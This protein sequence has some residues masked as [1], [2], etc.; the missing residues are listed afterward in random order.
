MKPIIASVL[1]TTA[2]TFGAMAITGDVAIAKFEGY[3]N[4][5]P[6]NCGVVPCVIPDYP[7]RSL[8]PTNQ[9]RRR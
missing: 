1:A 7:G 4:K 6:V 5:S 2:L 8:I 3:S 9:S